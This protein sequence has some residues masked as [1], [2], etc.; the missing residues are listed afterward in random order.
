MGPHSVEMLLLTESFITC[1]DTSVTRTFR[2]H[3]PS[4]FCPLPA[5]YRALC[6]SQPQSTASEGGVK[7]AHTV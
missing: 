1:C 6:Q 5:G 4:I 7:K 3:R 2:A